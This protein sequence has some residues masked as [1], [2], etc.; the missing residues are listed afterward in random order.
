MV[1]STANPSRLKGKLDLEGL[2]SSHLDVGAF[3]TALDHSPCCQGVKVEYS[4]PSEVNGRKAQQFRIS[5]Q[6]PFFQ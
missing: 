3:Y 6:L 2:A 5:C 4:K 1:R